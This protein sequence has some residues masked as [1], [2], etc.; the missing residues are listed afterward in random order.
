MTMRT[1]RRASTMEVPSFLRQLVKE[2]EKMVTFFFKGGRRESGTDVEYFENEEDVGSPY[3]KR[4]ILEKDTEEGGSKWGVNYGMASMQGW[5]AQM[6]DSHT[7]MPEMTDALPGWSY[8][9]VYD[10]HA[11]RTV[12]RYCSRH[13]LDFILDTGTHRLLSTII[14]WCSRPWLCYC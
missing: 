14:C 4:P 2:T 7:C 5:R 12:A 1:A 11:G 10:G 6:E 3:L 9:A 8:F 13:L